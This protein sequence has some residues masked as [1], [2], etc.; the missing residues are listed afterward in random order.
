MARIDQPLGERE[1]FVLLRRAFPAIGDRELSAAD[2]LVT[3]GIDSLG[4][5]EIL[6]FL[7][8][9]AGHALPDEV[10]SEL[11]TLGD[12]YHYYSLYFDRGSETLRPVVAKVP[13]EI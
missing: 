1:L 9:L 3:I 11:Q 10:V 12:V 7:G 5:F 4:F 2:R 13:S 6:E 8:E